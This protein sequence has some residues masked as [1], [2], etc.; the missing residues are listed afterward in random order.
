MPEPD[1]YTLVL[2]GSLND[3]DPWEIEV[4]AR[5]DAN[6]QGSTARWYRIGDPTTVQRMSWDRLEQH[7]RDRNA[8][9]GVLGTGAL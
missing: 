5:D 8:M 7:A 1:D 3:R 2:I 9:L 4:W 6:A